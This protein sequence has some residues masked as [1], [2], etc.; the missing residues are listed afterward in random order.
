MIGTSKKLARFSQSIRKTR[1]QQGDLGSG[2][3]LITLLGMMF[4][5]VSLLSLLITL[6]EN[7]SKGNGKNSLSEEEIHA[8]IGC[9]L[10]IEQSF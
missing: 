9:V 1:E 10:L 6:S 8:Q 3:D 2:N 5:S 7:A 4:V